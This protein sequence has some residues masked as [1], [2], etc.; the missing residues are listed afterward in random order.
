MKRRNE[1][2]RLTVSSSA[3]RL[4]PL[5]MPLFMEM[6]HCRLVFS[7]TLGLWRLVLSMMTAND[8]M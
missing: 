4:A 2:L 6:K 1:A 3:G 5:L 8:R 7:F